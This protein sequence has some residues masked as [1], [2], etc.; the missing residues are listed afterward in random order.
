MS[1]NDESGSV[2]IIIAIAL[3][4]LLIGVGGSIEASRAF[5]YRQRLTS[6][7]ELACLQAKAYIDARKPQDVRSTDATKLYPASDIQPIAD[8]VKV[9]KGLNASDVLTATNTTDINVH[10]SATGRMPI[11]FSSILKMQGVDFAVARDCPVVSAATALTS[12]SAPQLLF[13]ESFERPSHSVQYNSWSVLG[14]VKN[15]NSWNGW[16]TQN[17]GIEINGQRELAS[18]VVRFGDFFAELDSDCNTSANAGNKSC[19]SNST[20][21]R[22]MDLSPGN[23]QVRYWYIARQR[24]PNQPGRVICGAKDSDVSWYQVDGQTNRIEVYVEKS[25]NYTFAASSMVDVCV[26]AD[27]WTER[28][29]NFVVPVDPGASTTEYR[30]SWRAAGREDTYGGLIDY[31]RICRNS[32][33]S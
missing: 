3:P 15:G 28:V 2:A 13:T 31:L 10:V 26:Q 11:V 24:D 7:A 5:A 8:R 23:Y 6:A 29:I 12:S 22:I 25:G 14:G 33:P 30:I 9:A 20:M 17:A 27:A 16:T 21:S 18:N 1:L 4:A 32:C 19:H